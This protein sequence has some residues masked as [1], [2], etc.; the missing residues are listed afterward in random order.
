[1][2]LETPQTDPSSLSAL[3]QGATAISNS[4]IYGTAPTKVGCLDLDPVLNTLTFRQ[5][6]QSLVVV[7]FQ[8]TG[9]VTPPTSGTTATVTLLSSTVNAA[10]TFGTFVYSVRAQP[11]ETLV[12]DAT[13]STTVTAS[14]VQVGEYQYSLA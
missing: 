8:G 11:D 6:S 13:G 2:V 12:L 5:A 9:V 3:I 1:M 14:S 4:A 10:G 7:R